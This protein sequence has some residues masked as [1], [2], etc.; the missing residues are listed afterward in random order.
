M[1]AFKV[2]FLSGLDIWSM[3]AGIGAPSFYNILKMY[4]D[5]GC[6]TDFYDDISS[7]KKGSFF[8]RISSQ[9]YKPR[10]YKDIISLSPMFSIM[11]EAA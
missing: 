4:V 7:I 11:L 8:S 1:T 5:K 9:W 3:K 2:I 6:E 10:K